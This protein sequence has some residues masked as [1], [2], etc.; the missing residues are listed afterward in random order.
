MLA[1]PEKK[2]KLIEFNQPCECEEQAIMD[3]TSDDIMAEI[4]SYGFKGTKA[5]WD[6]SCCQGSGA[7]FSFENVDIDS[8][9]DKYPDRDLAA[10]LDNAKCDGFEDTW[11]YLSEHGDEP[12]FRG[13]FNSLSNHYTHEKTVDVLVEHDE[14]S[15]YDE[16]ALIV[17]DVI[18][19]ND[20]DSHLEDIRKEV[21]KIYYDAAGLLYKKLSDQWEWLH[22]E[23]AIIENLKGNGDLEF[24]ADGKCFK[25]DI[26]DYPDYTITS[27]VDD[28]EYV[29]INEDGKIWCSVKQSGQPDRGE[30]RDLSDEPDLGR[31]KAMIIKGKPIA[32]TIKKNIEQLPFG[33]P[34]VMLAEEAFKIEKEK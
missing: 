17:N 30:F 29:I 4:E 5:Q 32:Y 21:E 33:T 10:N 22:S 26:Y 28:V 19:T 15:E 8:L 34:E 25:P 23:E 1:D 16:A 12:I 2:A 14:I 9:I 20:W 18:Q 31:S 3:D 13:N 27:V 6:L 24:T 7:S 11:L